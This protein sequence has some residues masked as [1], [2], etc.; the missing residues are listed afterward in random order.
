[1][2]RK[3]DAGEPSVQLHICRNADELA[4]V[5]AAEID[6]RARAAIARRGRFCIALSGGSTPRR[7][8]ALM[9]TRQTGSERLPWERIQVFWGDERPVP[10]DDQESN[11]RF[12]NELLLSK[13]SIPEGNVHRIKAEMV[14][15]A[16]A[17]ALY[18]ADLRAFFATPVGRFPRFDLVLLG[19]GA[20]GHTASLFPG[21]DAIGERVRLVLAPVVKKLGGQRITIT[22]PVLNNARAVIFL[23]SGTSK[24]TALAHVLEGDEHASGLPATLVHPR[25]G[26]LLWFADRDAARGLHGDSAGSSPQPRSNFTP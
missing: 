2:T 1:M 16:A 19:L 20:D 13:V 23:V 5:A 9:A 15:P 12:A 8:Y 3:A 10:P 22:L 17:A 7:L 4:E 21:S 24:S 14:D 26:V 18:E 11:F 6:R 25:R